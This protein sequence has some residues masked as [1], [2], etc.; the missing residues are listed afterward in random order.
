[1]TNQEIIPAISSIERSIANWYS[2]VFPEIEP[3]EIEE[4]INIWAEETTEEDS[5]E[6]IL[7][8][9]ILSALADY[10]LLDF[11]NISSWLVP[12]NEDNEEE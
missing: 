4:N 11:N 9:E 12:K 8:S 3:E 10:H 1:M 2:N 6:S 7:L 5:N